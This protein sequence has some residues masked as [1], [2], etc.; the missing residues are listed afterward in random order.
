[1]TIATMV[2]ATVLTAAAVY[3]PV[4]EPIA[5]NALGIARGLA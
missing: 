3:W 4:L 2:L 1:M 5:F